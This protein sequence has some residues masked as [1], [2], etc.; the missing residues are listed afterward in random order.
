MSIAGHSLSSAVGRMLI[1]LRGV[2]VKGTLGVGISII[3]DYYL[4]LFDKIYGVHTSGRISLSAT[5]VER[6]KAIQATQYAPVNA[7]ALRHLFRDLNLPKSLRFAD[8]GCGLGRACMLAA[9]YGFVRVTGV[10]IVPEFCQVARDNAAAFRSR[11]VDST[12]IN[13]VNADALEYTRVTDDDVFFLYKPFESSSGFLEIV[14]ANLAERARQ[15]ERTRII[16]YTERF[17]IPSSDVGVFAKN[18]A[19][20][21]FR[22]WKQRGQIFYVYKCR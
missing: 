21:Q 15:S 4:K 1:L 3:E 9:E 7:W 10:D 8:I 11:V 22:L 16:I 6:S 13:I 14:L 19:F 12:A 2:G 18:Q 5:S 17:L 20:Q